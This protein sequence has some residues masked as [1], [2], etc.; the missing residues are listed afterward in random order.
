MPSQKDAVIFQTYF[1]V[2]ILVFFRF[3]YIHL[4]SN[5]MCK[6]NNLAEKNTYISEWKCIT[7]TSGVCFQPAM[8]LTESW[9]DDDDYYSNSYII[10]ITTIILVIIVITMI[11][12]YWFGKD[13]MM[14]TFADDDEAV[15]Q[16]LIFCH[17]S[18]WCFCLGQVEIRPEFLPRK[19]FLEVR[20]WSDQD[21]FCLYKIFHKM[22]VWNT[23]HVF[24]YI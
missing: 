23:Y 15:T 7:L 10:L 20:K 3:F 13:M 21:M 18:S 1:S 2:A 12:L 6:Y 4:R 8:F 14:I 9:I 24:T 19:Q 5:I 17:P 16:G 22:N 11:T